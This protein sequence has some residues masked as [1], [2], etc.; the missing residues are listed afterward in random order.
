MLNNCI[1]QFFNNATVSTVI[2]I[3][4]GA[5]IAVFQYK[6]QKQIDRLFLQKREVISDLILLGEKIQYTLFIFD[7]CANTYEIFCKGNDINSIKRFID[8]LKEYE[9][10]KISNVLN[11]EIPL[12]KTKIE[13]SISL[14]F[15]EE[16]EIINLH[17][18]F[19]KELEKWH[20]FAVNE[21]LSN[22]DF[23]TKK[24]SEISGLNI[25]ELNNCIKKIIDLIN[26]I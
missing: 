14:Y 3:V 26:K 23:F 17:N 10:P 20:E 5:C 15:F 11:E 19:E 4:I 16:K 12:L 22:I 21:P 9:I 1:Y 18:E 8:A 24:T 13:T 7:R 6:K 2:A 25:K